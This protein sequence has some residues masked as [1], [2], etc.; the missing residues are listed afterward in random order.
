MELLLFKPDEWSDTEHVVELVTTNP[1]DSDWIARRPSLLPL[2][3]RG[4]SEAIFWTPGAA[5]WGPRS[6]YSEEFEQRITKVRADIQG[7]LQ[8]GASATEKE[9]RRYDFLALYCLYCEYGEQ[10]DQF[11][12]TA[13]R[14][15]GKRSGEDRPSQEAERERVM[16]AMWEDFYSR[17]QNLFQF[18]HRP[19]QPEY[20][21]EHAFACFFLFRRAFYHIFFNIIGSS[22]AITKLRKAVWESIVTHDL[23]GLM[24]GFYQRMRDI[25]TLITGPSGTGKERVAEAIGRSLYIPFNS[26]KKAFDIDFLN[27]EKKTVRIDFLKA[28]NPVNLAALSP[29]LIESEV[30]GHVKGAFTGAVR[31]RIGRL[32]Q[33][34]EHGALFLDEIGEFTGEMQVKLLRVLETRRFQ[35]VGANEDERFLGKI[36]AATNRDLDAEMQVGRFRPDFYYRL[37]ADKIQTPSLREQLKDRP[38]DLPLFVEFVCRS[39]VGENRAAE[40]ARNVMGWIEQN[41]RGYDWPGNFRE[42]EQC[43]RSYLIRKEYHPAQRTQTEPDNGSPQPPCDSFREACEMLAAA[44]EKT[45]AACADQDELK[46]QQL[47]DQIKRRL[48]IQVRARTGTDQEAAT[49]LGIDVRTLKAGLREF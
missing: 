21:P 32:G 14:N 23:L 48:F 11:I 16:K 46:E 39:V 26:A 3:I 17:Y 12:D 37:C 35:R 25:P 8:D 13:V 15:Y 34:P 40:F 1:F 22:K 43:V 19:F 20:R 24:Q 47:F 44:V 6:V 28:F 2:P 36:I 27:A 38:A 18:K 42:L 9:W 30:F 29:Q 45:K 10:L 7:R 41:L 5:L 33:C 31:D 49:L 4:Y